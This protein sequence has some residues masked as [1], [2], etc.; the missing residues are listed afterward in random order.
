MA[1]DSGSGYNSAKKKRCGNYHVHRNLWK[2]RNRRIFDAK[3]GTPGLVLGFIK[4]DVALRRAACGTPEFEINL[5]H[6]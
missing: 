1:Q 3:T 2:E 5:V 4:E 6:P